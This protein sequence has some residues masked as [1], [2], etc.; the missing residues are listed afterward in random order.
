[1]LKD[2]DYIRKTFRL[3]EKARGKTS[4]NPMVGCVIVKKGRIIAEGFHR[5]AGL[6]HAE[7]E[8]LNNASEDVKGSVMY[9][10]LEPCFHWGMTPPCVDRI[11]SSEIKKVVISVKDP[12][13]EV[14]GKSITKMRREGI[15]VVAGVLK[16]EAEQLNE[17]FF[18][19]MKEGLP[20][21]AAKTAQTLDGKIADNRGGSKWITSS[22]SRKYARRLRCV[23]DAVLIGANTVRKD[24]PRLTCPEKKM[25]K[26]ILSSSLNIPLNARLFRNAKAVYIFTPAGP[27]KR[28]ILP[29]K[30]NQFK[31]KAEVIGIDGLGESLNLKDVL[32]KLYSLGVMSLFV[33][34]GGSVLGGFFDSKLVD[35]LYV[36]IA[37]KIMGKKQALASI[38]GRGDISVNNLAEINNPQVTSL[39][40]DYLFSGYPVFK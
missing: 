24:D 18:K 12:N 35:K 4:P 6:P 36:F 10:N 38:S 1:M 33:E 26:V 14:K 28:G 9:I 37:P 19:N 15:E 22:Y 39:G 13:P 27:A 8:A 23:Y 20:F 31:N 32:K 34:G 21:V 40:K 7:V 29:G 17:V 5:R 25:V 16:K 11:I 2:E 3:A 30:L